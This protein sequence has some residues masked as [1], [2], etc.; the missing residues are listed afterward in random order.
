MVLNILSRFFLSVFFTLLVVSSSFAIKSPGPEVGDYLV[1][2]VSIDSN[3]YN[4]TKRYYQKILRKNPSNLQSLDRLLLLSILEGDIQSAKNYSFKLA[5]VGCDQK[6]NACCMNNQSPQGHLINGISY[7]NSY[8]FNFADQSFASIWQGQISESTFVRLLRAWVWADKKNIEKSMAL[9]DLISTNEHQHFALLHKALIYDFVDDTELAEIFYDLYLSQRNDLYVVGLY[10]NFLERNDFKTKRDKVI[11][12]YL[13]GYDKTFR[14]SFL[15]NDKNRIIQN[16][17]QGIGVVLFNSSALIKD[18]NSELNH[19][20]YQLA[21][22][23]SPNLHEIKYLFSNF[24]INLGDLKKAQGILRMIP[25]KHYLG[26]YAAIQISD[27]YSQMDK[28]D[29]AVKNLINYNKFNKTFDSL[30]ALG[31]MYRYDKSWSNA[32]DAYESSLDIG[33]SQDNENIWEVFFN[34][35]IV[36]ERTDNWNEAENNFKTAL[37]IYEGQPDVLNYLGYSYLDKDLNLNLAKELIEKAMSLKPNDPYIIDSMAW[38][39]F[40]V[41]RYEEA[42]S[43]LDYAIDMMPYDSTIN[44]HYADALWKIGQKVQARFH[45]ERAIELDTEGEL[46]GRIKIKLLLGI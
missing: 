40:K 46:K 3:D 31:N 37:S 8:E 43:L 30:I 18:I 28:D 41:G 13:S 11:D 12:D 14:S 24:L 23:T 17:L 42:L 21:L 1:A 35:G 9:I 4:V 39:Y 36:H 5:R 45:W 38:Y 7:I 32:L 19:M 29:L 22:E 33:L 16:Q 26:E 6:R 25:K 2:K 34:I 15:T 44:E 27:L 10:L 20:L